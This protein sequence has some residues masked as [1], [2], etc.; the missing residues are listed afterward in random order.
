MLDEPTASIDPVEETKINRDFF[1]NEKEKT[2]IL[3]THRIGAA[4]YADRI[5]VMNRGEIVE[6][7]MHDEL[8]DSKGLYY[9]MYNTQ[10]K[11]YA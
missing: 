1:N 8:M 6:V 10:A 11:W 7:G 9:E 2:I 4:R 3:L 5:V